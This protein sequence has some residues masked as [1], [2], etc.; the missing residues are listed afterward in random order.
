[1]KAEGLACGFILVVQHD[2]ESCTEDFL[3]R[4]E[5]AVTRVASDTGTGY[6][7]IFVDVRRRASASKLRSSS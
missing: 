4:V 1:M 3:N 7:A 5:E 6:E 2:D